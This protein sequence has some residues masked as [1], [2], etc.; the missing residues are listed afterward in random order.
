MAHLRNDP[1]GRGTPHAPSASIPPASTPPVH[2]PFLAR[3]GLTLSVAGV[4]FSVVV[5][6]LAWFGPV[7]GGMLATMGAGDTGDSD[8]AVSPAPDP[9]A[10][11]PVE[12]AREVPELPVAHEAPA[13]NGTGSAAAAGSTSNAEPA[14]YGERV[15]STFQVR[16]RDVVIPYRVLAITALPGE[17]IEFVLDGLAPAA[18]ADAF[19]LRTA[20]GP[21]A[22]RE[23]GRWVW[24][25]PREPG[26]V[27]LRIESVADGDA[28]VLNVLVLHPFDE[29]EGG[30]LNGY[31]IG[32]YRTGPGRSVPPAGFVEAGDEVLELK[33]A[34]GFTLGQFISRQA[35]DPPYLALSEPLLLK[36]E[37]LLEEVRAE[38]IQVETLQVMSAFRTPHYNRAIGN[39][40]DGS[41]HLWGDAA[42]VY[43]DLGGWMGEADARRLYALAERVE[44]RGEEHVRP[45]GLS[46]YRANAVRGPF[47]HVDARG[48]P[49]RW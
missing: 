38:G 23:V 8:L 4:G 25:A 16:V 10:H 26:P 21:V 14:S 6:L 30:V 7:A 3:P 22:P 37:A 40:T 46:L 33:V 41:R 34:P 19:R 32:E 48:V 43:L 24:H 35:G 49:A 39:T 9:F 5:L 47:I 31:R 13:V 15:R 2:N 29:I 1:A 44:R 27:P 45:G 12:L 18:S 28:I 42:D 20:E 11:M 17:A 36:L